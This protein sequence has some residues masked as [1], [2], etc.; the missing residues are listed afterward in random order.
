[1][2]VPGRMIAFPGDQDIATPAELAHYLNV[3][4]HGNT[5]QATWKLARFVPFDDPIVLE[6]RVPETA[7]A[8]LQ[9]FLP[10]ITP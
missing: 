3:T 4:L 8:A 5:C 6:G 2:H 1:M 9:Q 10:V 7:V